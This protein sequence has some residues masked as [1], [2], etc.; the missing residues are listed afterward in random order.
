MPDR[1]SGEPRYPVRI[2]IGRTGLSADVLRAWER[3]YGAVRPHRSTAGQ[4]LYTEHDIARLM[5]LRRATLDGHRIG[6]VARLETT[7]LEALLEKSPSAEEAPTGAAVDALLHGAMIAV[8]RLDAAS[9]ESLLKRGALALGSAAFVDDVVTR[10]LVDIGERWHDGTVSPAQEHLASGVIRRVL[11]WMIGTYVVAPRAP[12]LIIATPAGEQH[13]LG[14]MLTAVAAVEEGWR[15]VYLGANLPAAD[16]ARA[17]RQLRARAVALSAVNTSATTMP[18]EVR[19]TARALPEG[20]TLFV[21]GRA[22]TRVA[23]R[24]RGA[25]IRVLPDIAA[26]RRALRTLRAASGSAAHDPV[27]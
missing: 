21:G 4:R 27:A 13:E 23:N 11:D 24:L 2:V 6:E 19:A 16:I 5:L 8:D 14:A 3:R 22:A 26:L 10:F 1:T 25:N 7:A 17:A 9:L 20:V 18:A 15:A 12:H